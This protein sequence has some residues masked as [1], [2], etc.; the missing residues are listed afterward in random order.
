MFSFLTQSHF[1]DSA[2]IQQLLT[3]NLMGHLNDSGLFGTFNNF[4][5]VYYSFI[6]S[7]GSKEKRI[8]FCNSASANKHRVN[9]LEVK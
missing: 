8:S 5:F 9:T 3:L 2:L 7:H 6:V 4:T 1:I